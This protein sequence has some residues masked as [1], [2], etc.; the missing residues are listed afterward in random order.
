MVVLPWNARSQKSRPGHVKCDQWNSMTECLKWS[1]L[2]S[3]L[4]FRRVWY[5]V[6]CVMLT[7]LCSR[8][9]PFAAEPTTNFRC[10][11]CR[12][13]LIFVFLFNHFRNFDFD[14]SG[15]CNK[16][17]SVQIDTSYL[18]YDTGLSANTCNAGSTLEF[19]VYS[20]QKQLKQPLFHFLVCASSFSSVSAL[21][22]HLVVSAVDFSG[23]VYSSQKI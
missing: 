1:V 16:R 14:N 11:F 21:L 8:S 15:T 10:I 22:S 20:F 17:I 5:T 9:A 4:C 7:C 19:A 6:L 23:C 18:M 3:C 12:H 2:V 13:V